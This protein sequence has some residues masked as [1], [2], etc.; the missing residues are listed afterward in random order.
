M[1]PLLLVFPDRKDSP[2]SCM[3]APYVAH[4]QWATLGR[5]FSFCRVLLAPCLALDVSRETL[6]QK[7]K[8]GALWTDPIWCATFPFVFGLKEK[9]RTVSRETV[10][11]ESLK[12][13]K[14]T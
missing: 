6:T 12:G 13:M 14:P 3:P 9:P 10:R 4:M 1:T 11:G 5:M 7:D 2:C 8:G